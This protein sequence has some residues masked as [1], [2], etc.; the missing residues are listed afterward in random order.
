MKKINLLAIG[1][2]LIVILPGC[3]KLVGKGPVVTENRTISPFQGLTLGVPANAYFTQAPDY[4]I[5]LRAQQN[6]LDE[7]ETVIVND[8]LKIRF[9]HPGTSVRTHEE[10]TVYVRAPEIRN[11]EVDGSGNLNVSPLTSSALRLF[12]SGSGSMHADNIEAST[13]DASISGSGTMKVNEGNANSETVN[14]SGSAVIDLGGVM[15]KDADT[16]ISGSGVIKVNASKTLTAHLS[17]SGTVFYYGTPS[18]ST[19]ISGSGSVVK[20]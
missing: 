15:V 8:E 19:S 17:G 12:I 4:S 14:I 9:R 1:V 16:H 6:I 13:I 10:I 5:E 2:L 20:L 7:I 3:E 18:V 11:L